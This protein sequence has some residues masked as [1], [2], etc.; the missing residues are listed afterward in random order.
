MAWERRRRLGRGENS[1]LQKKHV[2]SCRK[3][4]ASG[5]KDPIE[6]T[7]GWGTTEKAF[8]PAKKGRKATAT[9]R[10]IPQGSV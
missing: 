6:D 8:A 7:K 3:R 5:E 9:K 1:E 4:K 2:S 10:R